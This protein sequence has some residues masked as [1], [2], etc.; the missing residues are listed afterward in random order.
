MK[1]EEI[2]ETWNEIKQRRKETKTR[3]DASQRYSDN[4][5]LADVERDSQKFHRDSTRRAFKFFE[6]FHSLCL[7]GNF[8]AE[9]ANAATH[10]PI[11]SS[12]LR[13][14]GVTYLS[15]SLHGGLSNRLIKYSIG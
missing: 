1:R 10:A 2:Q 14:V 7:R 13:L 6:P 8:H 3:H 12:S 15:V 4:L 9:F 5:S 11:L